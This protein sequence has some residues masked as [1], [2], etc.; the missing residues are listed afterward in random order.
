MCDARRVVVAGQ[1]AIWEW[2][3]V[4]R[5]GHQ[6][7]ECNDI[8]KKSKGGIFDFHLQN[9]PVTLMMLVG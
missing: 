9:P 1:Q 2:I 4:S 5:R 7:N 8:W 3:R 6:T